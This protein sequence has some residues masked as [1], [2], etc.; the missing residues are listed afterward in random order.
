M[1]KFVLRRQWERSTL[2]GFVR[3]MWAYKFGQSCYN[4]GAWD[5]PPSP[6][7]KG[8]MFLRTQFTTFYRS[9]DY[10]LFEEKWIC[11]KCGATEG[12]LF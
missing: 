6:P 12:E 4:S 3:R 9:T 10:P 7:C 1:D 5:K 8:R 11:N 2:L